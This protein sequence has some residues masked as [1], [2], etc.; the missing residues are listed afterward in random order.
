MRAFTSLIGLVLLLPVAAAAQIT[1]NPGQYEYTMDLDLGEANAGGKAVLDAAGFKN[2]KRVECLT[3]EDVKEKD[4]WKL[5]ERAM[6]EDGG[7][8]RMSN[9]KTAGNK[10]TFTMTCDEDDE[11]MVMN[12]EMTFLG[13]SFVSLTKTKLPD[14][15]ISNGRIVAKRLG[16]CPK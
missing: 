14:G 3:P 1:I 13:D 16:D 7:N 11:Q 15:Q 2:N 10:M 5:L 9:Q 4:V 6:T 8:C 12:T